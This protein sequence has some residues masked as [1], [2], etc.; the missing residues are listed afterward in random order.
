MAFS[1]GYRYALV[2]RIVV[3]LS[4]IMPFTS[5][6]AVVSALPVVDLVYAIHQASLSTAS[7][8]I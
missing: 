7:F 5:A 8:H 4:L 1:D 3:L 6:A 2:S